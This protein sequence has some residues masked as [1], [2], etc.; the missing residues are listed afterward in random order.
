MVSS[1]ET[2]TGKTLSDLQ[3]FYKQGNTYLATVPD[4][5]KVNNN[6]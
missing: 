1:L 4:Q 3:A 5:W 6:K 2:H